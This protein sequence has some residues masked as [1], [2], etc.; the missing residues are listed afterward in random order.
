[1]NRLKLILELG[2][3]W[4]KLCLKYPDDNN[5]DG[6]RKLAIALALTALV[7]EEYRVKDWH[8]LLPKKDNQ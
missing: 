5:P 4:R 3:E 2:K 8:Q 7:E 1:M 6:Y